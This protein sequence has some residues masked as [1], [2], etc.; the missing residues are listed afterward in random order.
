VERREVQQ[1]ALVAPNIA[2]DQVRQMAAVVA[3][4][5]MLGM[6]ATAG[7][8]IRLLVKPAR[9]AAAVAAVVAVA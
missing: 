6:V 9:R 5:D 3:Q 1:T 8:R 4:P 7:F 2:V